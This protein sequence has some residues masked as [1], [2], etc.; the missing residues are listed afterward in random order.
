MCMVSYVS[1]MEEKVE[2]IRRVAKAFGVDMS[3]VFPESPPK[4]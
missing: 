1:E 4:L 2:I 3:D